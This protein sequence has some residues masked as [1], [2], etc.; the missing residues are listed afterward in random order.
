MT[1]LVSRFSLATG[2]TLLA[3]YLLFIPL[4]TQLTPLLLFVG[5]VDDQ[6]G[7]QVQPGYWSHPVG[8]LPACLA[9]ADY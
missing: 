8:L 4:P 5:G 3:S 2:L 1:T 6:P 7:Q 9:P